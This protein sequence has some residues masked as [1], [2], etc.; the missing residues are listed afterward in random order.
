M[1]KIHFSLLS[2]LILAGCGENNQS[3]VS[4]KDNTLFIQGV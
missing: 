4:N 3:I 2:F 1:K